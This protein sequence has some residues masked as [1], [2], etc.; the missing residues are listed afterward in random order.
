VR[1]L[2]DLFAPLGA[3]MPGEVGDY[4]RDHLNNS[5]TS[6]ESYAEENRYGEG[7]RNPIE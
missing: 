6:G 4:W 2:A 5:G 3:L 1:L 7:V